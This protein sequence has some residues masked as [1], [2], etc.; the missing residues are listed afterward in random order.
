MRLWGLPAWA[1]VGFTCAALATGCTV[2]APGG[3]GLS[4]KIGLPNRQN[5]Y[6]GLD[7][8]DLVLAAYITALRDENLD[9]A[10]AYLVLPNPIPDAQVLAD[11]LR[12][13][14]RD[15]RQ[16]GEAVRIIDGLASNHFAVV[17]YSTMPD[18]SDA[19]PVML[20]KGP[21]MNWRLHHRLTSG[22]IR[23]WVTRREELEELQ[24]LLRWAKE[25][26][27]GGA[28]PAAASG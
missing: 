24:S 3:T 1:L 14:S 25:R 12:S 7:T 4:G 13:I 27:A 18:Q 8:P 11:Q 19:S 22:P 28:K 2:L 16:S 26:L 15:I 20:V 21:D 5:P 9:L 6:A 23:D 10:R 17:I